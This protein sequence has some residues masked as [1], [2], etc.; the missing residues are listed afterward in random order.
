[1]YIIDCTEAAEMCSN[2]QPF[3]NVIK[4]FLQILRWSVPLLLVVLGT[5]DMF[6]AVTK[7]DD[8]KVVTEAR[9]AF[10][11]RLIYGVLVFLIPFFVNLIL[12]LVED[13]IPSNDDSVSATTWIS[14]WNEN[15]DMSSC[16][17]IYEKTETES[18]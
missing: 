12:G 18:K 10:V 2:L 9:K 17:N 3:L 14:C 16:T 1:M 6:K 4:L 5:I 13:T 8:E 11:K 15:V 7:A